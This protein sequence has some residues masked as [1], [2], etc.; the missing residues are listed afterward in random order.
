MDGNAAHYTANK[1]ILLSLKTQKKGEKKGKKNQRSPPSAY[2]LR[3]LVS[4]SQTISKLVACC[5]S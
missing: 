1:S 2:G 3:Y 4:D 5:N